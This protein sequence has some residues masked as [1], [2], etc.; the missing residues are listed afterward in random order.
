[1]NILTYENAVKALYCAQILQESRVGIFTKDS[2]FLR[3]KA[4][5]LAKLG[6]GKIY[7]TLSYCEI[8]LWNGSTITLRLPDYS[9]RGLIFDYVL[10]DDEID[11]ETLIEVIMPTEKS[12]RMKVIFTDL[13]DTFDPKRLFE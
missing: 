7:S 1:M 6:H 9:V 2:S 10:Y 4:E 5:Y 12:Q 13:M 3:D 8:R 11:D